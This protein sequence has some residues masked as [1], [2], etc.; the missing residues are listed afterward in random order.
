MR[1]VPFVCGMLLGLAVAQT[2]V[3]TPVV[4]SAPTR[5]ADTGLEMVLPTGFAAGEPIAGSLFA[6]V[7]AD[8]GGFRENLNLTAGPEVMPKVADAELKNEMVAALGKLLQDYEFVE[9]G[10]M[11]VRGKS[12]WWLSSRF[13]Q[14]G[15]RLRN[16]QVLVPGE[17][18]VWFTFTTTDEAFAARQPDI[19]GKLATLRKAGEAVVASPVVVS[20]DGRR[21]IVGEYGFSF[22]PPDGWK[23]G[24]AE[25]ALGAFLFVVGEPVD[26]FAP[27]VNV[28]AAP[29]ASRM[30][31]RVVRQELEAGLPK[32]FDSTVIHEC[33]VRTVGKL[34][35]VRARVTCTKGDRK[36]HVVLYYVPG[37]PHSFVVT[38]TV[39]EADVGKLL[40]RLDA[41]A[42]T[43]ALVEPGARPVVAGKP[44]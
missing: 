10:R 15:V 35:P 27:N 33:A 34:K 3:P 43:I 39:A 1:S 12:A 9:D 37:K 29:A 30:D 24:A 38:Y 23:Q 5:L 26:G 8:V 16:L 21:L 40:A 7:G 11:D 13:T 22:E 28:R 25:V 31:P 42:A 19:R 36:L 41:S 20:A 32:L 17:P 18:C 44:K 4:A 14:D 2:P 6:A